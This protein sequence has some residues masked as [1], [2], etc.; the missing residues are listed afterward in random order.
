M[1]GEAMDSGDKATN[2]AMS[3]AYKYMA[4]QE[5]C[6]PTEGDNDAD[7][8]TH[9]LASAEETAVAM[10]QGCV[11]SKPQFKDAWEKNKDGWKG[12]GRPRLRPRGRRDEAR[13][14][15]R[16]TNPSPRP[17]RRRLRHRRRRNPLLGATR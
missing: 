13:R 12:A 5:F 6:I 1:F 16:R 4:M 3:A 8:A 17:P 11:R 10:L 7:A 15:S 9:Q 2:K 14:P